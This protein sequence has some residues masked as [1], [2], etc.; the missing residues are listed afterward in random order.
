MNGSLRVKLIA[1]IFSFFCAKD[2]SQLRLSAILLSCKK[3]H[4]FPTTCHA[5]LNEQTSLITEL[6]SRLIELSK[7]N[8]NCKREVDELNLT[9]RKLLEGKRRKPKNRDE[10]FPAH[11]RREFVDALLSDAERYCI[12]HGERKIIRYDLEA[13][14]SVARWSDRR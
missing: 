7:L 6:E 14:A 5:L 3:Q 4:H 12:E 1:N 8:E 10:K 9:V 11:L 13:V 2:L